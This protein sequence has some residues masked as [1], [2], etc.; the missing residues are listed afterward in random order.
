MRAEEWDSSF[1]EGQEVRSGPSV[2]PTR[3]GRLPK[4]SVGLNVQA[5]LKDLLMYLKGRVIQR[6]GMKTSSFR[7][8]T[9]EVV[10]KVEAGPG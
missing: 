3:V 4:N 5:C 1:R 2:P 10:T 9:P 7:S 6:E 8:L